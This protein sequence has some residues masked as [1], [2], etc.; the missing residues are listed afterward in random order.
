MGS[1]IVVPLLRGDFSAAQASFEISPAHRDEL[2]VWLN[3]HSHIKSNH[4][5]II[6]IVVIIVVIT[7]FWL[8]MS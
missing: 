2:C 3:S 8:M 6:S 4:H 7:A 1:G 5:I